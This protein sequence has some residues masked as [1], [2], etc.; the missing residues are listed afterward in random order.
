MNKSKSAF[1][2]I[3]FLACVAIVTLM[4]AIIIPTAIKIHRIDDSKRYGTNVTENV[5]KVT[6]KRFTTESMAGDG[7]VLLLYLITDTKTGREYL[8]HWNGGMVS[9]GTTN[10]VSPSNL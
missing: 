5:M 9:L 10:N 7:Q 4:A 1:A 2:L 6:P 3:E 8:A